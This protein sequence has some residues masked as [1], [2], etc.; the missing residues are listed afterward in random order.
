MSSDVQS[1]AVEFGVLGSASTRLTPYEP[2]EPKTLLKECTFNHTKDPLK[3]EGIFL[4][5]GALGSLGSTSLFRVQWNCLR[6]NS[7][8]GNS[9]LAQSSDFPKDGVLQD[10]V[11]RAIAL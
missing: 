8:L 3:I 1:G 4:M 5:L 6:H 2:K 9:A 11:V 7:C 10:G